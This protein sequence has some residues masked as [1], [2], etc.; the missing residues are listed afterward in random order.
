MAGKLEA[1]KTGRNDRCSFLKERL[2]TTAAV[3]AHGAHN[4]KENIKRHNQ[5]PAASDRG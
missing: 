5:E 4:P 1:E 2:T 3:M